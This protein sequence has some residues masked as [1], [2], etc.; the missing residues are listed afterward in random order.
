MKLETLLKELTERL[1]RLPTRSPGLKP[2]PAVARRDFEFQREALPQVGC[3]P[4]FTRLATRKMAGNCVDLGSANYDIWLFSQCRC[5]RVV[6]EAVV[7]KDLVGYITPPPTLATGH[8]RQHHRK[9]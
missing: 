5:I 8:L 6:V 2:N 3:T 9:D 7:D 4:F 1:Y